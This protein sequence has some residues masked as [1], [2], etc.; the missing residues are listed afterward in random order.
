MRFLIIGGGLSGLA[1]A[2]ALLAKGHDF[3]VLEARSRFG[4]RMKS[5]RFA[6][7]N[8]DMGPAWFWPEQPR[9]SAL[10]DKLGLTRFD[11]FSTGDLIY[12]D[13][14]GR[15]Q[16]GRGISSMKGSWRIV[17]GFGAL[18]DAMATP[19]PQ[20]QWRLNAHVTHLSQTPNGINATLSD[21]TKIEADHVILA[22]PP[23]MAANITFTPSLPEN[24]MQAMQ[25]VSTWM[26]GQAK[27]TAVYDTPF[28]RNDV[29]SGDAQSRCGPMVEI[30]DASPA[31]EDCFALFGFIGVPAQARR[32]E[33]ALRQHLVAQLTRLF[34]PKAAEPT[35]LFVKDW[36]LDPHTATQDDL[37]PLF[38]HPHYGL[39]RSMTGLWNDKLHFAGTEVAPEFGG[40]IEGALEAA[41]NVLTAIET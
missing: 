12:E 31:S 39:P 20:H 28:W 14:Q 24:A 5:E 29:L 15:A 40:Y 10:I 11:Q 27:A 36:A 33:Q 25:N 17:G 23:R 32:D 22:L 35:Q 3:T 8:F 16:R 26:A 37:A 38:A 21:G 19:I 4:G 41:E 30:H 1:V 13:E 9:I 18:I 2:H 6:G 7:N 34:G